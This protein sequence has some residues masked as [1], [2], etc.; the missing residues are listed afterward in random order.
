MITPSTLPTAVLLFISL[1]LYPL[2]SQ[3][4]SLTANYEHDAIERTLQILPSEHPASATLGPFV[5]ADFIDPYITVEAEIFTVQSGIQVVTRNNYSAVGYV[6]NDDYIGFEN[7]SFANGP[8]TGTIRAASNSAG[9]L[10]EFRIGSRNGTVIAT[11]A[12]TNTGGWR[13]FEQFPITITN[14]SAYADGSESLGTT[15]LYLTFSGGNGYLLDVDHFS[16]AQADVQIQSLAFNNCPTEPILVGDVID[17]NV[18]LLPTNTT[19]Q[20][21]AFT[22]STGSGVDYLSGSFT[23]QV[24]GEITVFAT[25]FSDGGVFDQCTITVS[26]PVEP[27]GPTVN[28]LVLVNADTDQDIAIINEGDVFSIAET[29]TSNL[30]VRA[31]VSAYTESVRF[32]YQGV[33][34]YQIE[35]VPVYAIGGN[36]GNNY[37]AW[38]PDFG[39]NTITAVAYTGNGATGLAGN[40]TT[41]NFEFLDADPILP[42][43]L[44]INCG[45]P[46]ITYGDSIFIADDFFSGNGKM[47][48]NNSI[49][50]ILETTQDAIYKTERSTLA[51]LQS[52]TYSFPV[53]NGAYSINL[54]FAEIYFGATGGGAGGINK[55]VFDVT[56][57]GETILDDFDINAETG[58]M[59]AIIQ[60][61]TANVTDGSIDLTFTASIDQPKISAIEIYGEGSLTEDPAACSWSM[62]A[63]SSLSKVEAQSVKVNDKLYVLAGFLSG[64]QITG[65]TEIYD[66]ATDSWST[67]APMPTPVTH[68]GA[69]AVGDEIWILA[70]FVGNHPGVATNLVQIYNTVTDTWSEGPALPNSRGS[71]AGAYTDG[72]V[73]FF[74]GLLPNRMTDVGEH[75]VMDV[76]DQAAGWQAAA[77]LPEPRNHLGGAAVNGI[78][79]AIGGQFGH[80]GGVDDQR[81]LHAYDPA[82]DTWTQLADLPDDRS[83]FEP[84]TIVH[85]DKIIIVGGRRGGF[86]FD[87]VTEYDPA[88]D[89]WSERCEL[90]S[91]LLAPAAK[92]FGSQLIVANGGENGTC[93]PQSETLSIPIEPEISSQFR[94]LVYHETAGFR[95]GSINAGIEMIEEFGLANNWIVEE[96]Q[97]SSVFNNAN[98]S[99]VNVV[100]WLNTSG[101]GLLTA[102][103]QSAFESYIQSG[104]GFV[105]VHAATDTYRNGS[106]PWFN[107]LVGAI[108]QTSPN[109]TSNNYNATMD[110]V[111]SHPAV[112]HLDLE[113]NKNEEYYYWELNGGYLF[114]GNIDLLQVRSTGSQSYDAP[115]PITW[116]KEFDGGRSF[117]TALGHNSSDYNGNDD[118]RTMVEEA[119]L[120]AGGVT[121]VAAPGLREYDGLHEHK[122]AS[123]ASD[124]FTVFPNP[125]TGVLN[126]HTESDEMV[127]IKLISI[128]GVL[129]KEIHGKG[130]QMID[131]SALKQ[132][133]Y[134]LYIHQGET[135][136]QLKVVKG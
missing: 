76:N 103:E 100:V 26:E 44:R 99:D 47:Y 130:R 18:D 90:P 74:G 70:G 2:S 39:A 92:V 32:D 29:G 88:T 1:L 106:W 123:S 114:D 125:T 93:C 59:T 79:Y 11:A 101:D 124:D 127:T 56:L 30:N 9:G 53:T 108:V 60:T 68:M 102:A 54:H 132:G 107:D 5:A 121:N 129:I 136:K 20:T 4:K 8:A 86:F 12:I 69:V 67:G 6:N 122:A 40:P 24:A 83:H 119:I 58:S 81:F 94:V 97:S 95:H 22:T 64:L 33:V 112:E 109:H 135:Q 52:F 98:L 80:D 96:G 41:V 10:I 45:G 117:Y 65:A 51:S 48:A 118:F 120:W 55:R 111:G 78:I 85:N 19:N 71:G 14:P 73:H 91:N 35:S 77:P 13:T 131:I 105:G 61:F 16:F 57:E 34:N 49:S 75:F 21:V 63:S 110:V 66:P 116:Y 27:D 28:A 36:S 104:G 38:V 3:A 113:W 37:N 126:I 43:L 133:I 7:V 15:S 89:T 115:R 46:T 50:D 17:L 82:N 31:E 134:L 84:G 62:L 128:T 25:S 23:A 87:D 72:K 42:A